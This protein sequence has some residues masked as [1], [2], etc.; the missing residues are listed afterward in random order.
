MDNSRF[1]DYS[2]KIIVKEE[3][4]LIAGVITLTNSAPV[5]V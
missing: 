5:G 2:P 4:G 1:V 3:A